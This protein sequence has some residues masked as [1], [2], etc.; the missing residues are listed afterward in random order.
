[1]LGGNFVDVRV[2][3]RTVSLLSSWGLLYRQAAMHRH[4]AQSSVRRFSATPTEVLP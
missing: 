4:S 2:A 3:L 1:V